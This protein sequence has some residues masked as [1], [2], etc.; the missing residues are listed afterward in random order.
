MA[1]PFDVATKYLVE[2]DPLAWVKFLGLPGA[3]AELMEADL[4]TIVAEA[5]R[6]LRI[7]DPDYLAHLEMQA[8]Y[9]PDVG[10]RIFFYNAV[11]YYKYRLPVD[12]S[13]ILLRKE[14]DGPAMTGKVAYGSLQF[15]YRVIRLWEYTPEDLLEAPLA[16]LALAPITNVSED[17][18]PEVIRRMEA[19]LE[20]EASENRSEFWTTTWLLMGLKYTPELS[21]HLLRGVRNMK[22]SSTYQYMMEEGREEGRRIGIQEGLQEGLQKGL[23]EG[24][25]EGI[26][27]GIREGIQEGQRN[28]ARRLLVLIGNKRLGEPDAKSKQILDAVSSLPMLEEWVSRVYEVESWQELL[29]SV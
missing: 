10:D 19:R 5:D 14:A 2:T 18:L 22:E 8:A 1:K 4:S 13:V 11:T 24:L 25:R 17:D 3:S 29:S 16:L 28:E 9:K 23:R 20:M 27:E 6:I 15:R 12:S 26:Q 21:K 7:T